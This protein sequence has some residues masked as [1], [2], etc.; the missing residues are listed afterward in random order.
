MSR[1]RAL[2][3]DVVVAVV[4]G[5]WH[6]G[7]ADPDVPAPIVVGQSSTSAR[8]A[9]APRTTSSPAPPVSSGP[10]IVPPPTVGPTNPAPDD[11]DDA[12]DG[13]DVDDDADDGVDDDGG[14]GE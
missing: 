5:R 10:S 4:A 2:A 1:V 6:V 3:L 7:S 12:D 14:D 11:D 9:P 8:G 13:S